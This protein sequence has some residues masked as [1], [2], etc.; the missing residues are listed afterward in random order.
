MPRTAALPDAW[1]PKV[2]A[3]LAGVR[4]DLARRP[5]RPLGAGHESVALLLDAES[6]TYVLRFP[7]GEA[8]AASIACEARLLPELAGTLGVPIPRFAFTARTRSA[9]GRSAAT[10]SSRGSR[11]TRRTGTPAACWTSRRPPAA[12]PS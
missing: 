6:D 5:L 7:R 4:P 10:P 1:E 2:R 11:W 12:S 3:A 9:P 8:G